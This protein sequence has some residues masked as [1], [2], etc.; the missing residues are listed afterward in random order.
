MFC[1][2]SSIGCKTVVGQYSFQTLILGHKE[3][4]ACDDDFLQTRRTSLHEES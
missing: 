1:G 2:E 3:P 4:K